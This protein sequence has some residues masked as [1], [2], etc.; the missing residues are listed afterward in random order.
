MN[1]LP[2]CLNIEDAGVLVVSGGKAAEDQPEAH[3]TRCRCRRNPITAAGLP[4][5]FRWDKTRRVRCLSE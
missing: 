5:P 3:A 2:V 4:E 1:F